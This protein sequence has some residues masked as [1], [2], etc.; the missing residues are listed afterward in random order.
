MPAPSALGPLS[1]VVGLGRWRRWLQ[2][3]PRLQDIGRQRGVPQRQ[4]LVILGTAA[5]G[6]MPP[7][8]RQGFG[9]AE[10]DLLHILEEF[11]VSKHDELYTTDRG[12]KPRA[13]GS[14]V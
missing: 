6:F 12:I 13:V 2:G 7:D 9:E 5:I 1:L 10:I 11:A 4:H 14:E 8:Q 3:R